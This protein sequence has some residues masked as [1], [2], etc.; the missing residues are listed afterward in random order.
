MDIFSLPIAMPMGSICGA[1]MALY[2]EPTIAAIDKGIR[3]TEQIFFCR[4]SQTLKNT[5]EQEHK[6]KHKR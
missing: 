2:F 4:D 6:L 5:T 1:A 3:A